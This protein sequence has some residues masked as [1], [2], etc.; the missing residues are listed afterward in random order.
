MVME[1]L[2]EWFEVGDLASKVMAN[3]SAFVDTQ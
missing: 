1:G 3:L 2:W